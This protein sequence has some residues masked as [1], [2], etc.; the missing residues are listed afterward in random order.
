MND[1]R[2]ILI[3]ALKIAVPIFRDKQKDRP[4]PSLS[5]LDP[6]STVLDPLCTAIETCEVFKAV[7]GHMLFSGS[8]GILLNAPIL[9]MPLLYK[10][11]VDIAAAAQWLISF[12]RTREAKVEFKAAIWGLS[13]DNVVPLVDR[14]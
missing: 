4:I 10:A 2:E 1:D 9:A 3:E 7:A 11:Q 5:Q 6:D 12:L 8:S 14:R 13:V